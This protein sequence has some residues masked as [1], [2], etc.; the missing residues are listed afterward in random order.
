MGWWLVLV[1]VIVLASV[2]PRFDHTHWDVIGGLLVLTLY[3]AVVVALAVGDLDDEFAYGV[4]LVVVV[5]HPLTLG[6]HSPGA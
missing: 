3:V 1:I 2:L 4:V 6:R 5:G